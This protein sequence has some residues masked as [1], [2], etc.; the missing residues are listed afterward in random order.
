MNE[1]MIAELA[2]TMKDIRDKLTSSSLG[3]IRGPVADPAPDWPGGHYGPWGAW[4][5]Q[6]S[7]SQIAHFRGPIAD[8][9][10]WHLLDKVRIAKLK[11]SQIQ[12]EI[13]ELEK[14]IDFLKLQTQLLKEEY[15]L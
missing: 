10:P 9:A 15:K 3:Y 8:P 14:Q 12:M 1:K 7:P 6:I 2:A 4:G 11:V 5:T 13:Q